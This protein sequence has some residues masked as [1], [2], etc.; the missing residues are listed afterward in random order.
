MIDRFY[1][2]P[3][4]GE[5]NIEKLQSKRHP[6]IWE[7]G[8]KAEKPDESE[9]ASDKAKDV[10]KEEPIGEYEQLLQALIGSN[11]TPSPV[12]KSPTLI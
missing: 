7:Q 5:M 10:G 3:L 8:Y 2:A 1:A 4:Q 11:S 12:N 6:R 9:K